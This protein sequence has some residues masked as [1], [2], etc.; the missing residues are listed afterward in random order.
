MTL[1]RSNLAE[2]VAA[3]ASL[4]V[5][6]FADLCGVYAAIRSHP[7]SYGL[8]AST[9]VASHSPMPLDEIIS[10]VEAEHRRREIKGE[11]LVVNEL[12]LLSIGEAGVKGLP[13]WKDKRKT[14]TWCEHHKSSSHNTVD[15][16]SGPRATNT[17]WLSAE[18]YKKRKDL[19]RKQKEQK[20]L[21]T[22]QSE[23]DNG[24][25]EVQMAGRASELAF[26]SRLDTNAII[27]YSYSG[28]TNNFV[29]D[30][31]L[32][33]N[34]ALLK[35]PILIEV[36]T[37]RWSRRRIKGASLSK[38]IYFDDSYYVPSMAHNLLSVHRMGHA[39]ST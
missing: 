18:D 17:V 24:Q 8:L 22:V 10:R 3:T 23:E 34:L 7:S 39:A 14:N 27:I 16:R 26:S 15:C 36:G 32:L 29:K 11:V 1:I 28:A 20:G 9:L 21:V 37:E 13:A 2:I 38:H 19:E 25:E 30:A 5:G 12:G 31:N 6:G 33:T 35:T 4:T